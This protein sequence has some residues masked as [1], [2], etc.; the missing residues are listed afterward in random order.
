[1]KKIELGTRLSWLRAYCVIVVLMSLCFLAGTW[2]I[3]AGLEQNTRRFTQSQAQISQSILEAELESSYRYGMQLFYDYNVKNMEKT[4]LNIFENRESAYLTSVS[5]W[6]HIT[7]NPIIEDFYLYYPQSDY[8][9]GSKGVYPT[10][11]YGIL[12]NVSD[13]DWDAEQ[14]KAEIFAREAGF[15]L[16]TEDQQIELYYR[17][18]TTND[19][20]RILVAKLNASEIQKVLEYIG[21]SQTNNLIAIVDDQNTIYSWSGDYNRFADPAT[22]QLRAIDESEF[23]FADLTS[24]QTPL[25]Y[26][27]ITE[28]NAACRAA[29]TVSWI[30]VLCI[31]F[32]S[33]G[34]LLLSNYFTNKNMLPLL[35]LIGRY[36]KKQTQHET[37]NEMQEL[38]LI[39]DELSHESQEA[40]LSIEQQ[41]RLLVV[42]AFLNE[43]FKFQITNRQT[44]ANLSAI[45]DLSFE[46]TNYIVIVQERTEDY[47]S[48]D[49][50]NLLENWDD[51][52]VAVFWAQ[53]DNLDTFLI[54]FD[55]TADNGSPYNAFLQQLQECTKHPRNLAISSRTDN[56]EEIRSCWLD[57]LRQ[58]K[59]DPLSSDLNRT[60]A[61]NFQGQVLYNSFVQYLH[62]E[63]YSGAIN[64]APQLFSVYLNCGSNLERECKR[65]QIIRQLLAVQDAER[66]EQSIQNLADEP[67]DLHWKDSLCKVLSQ[68]NSVHLMSRQALYDGGTAA[69]IRAFIEEEYRNPSMD[70]RMVSEY[71]GLSESYVSK[72]FKKEYQIGISQYLNLVRIG[73]AKKWLR[74]DTL[75]I[76]AIALEVGYASDAHFIRIFKKLEGIT[77]GA[78][79]YEK[80]QET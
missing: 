10:E 33:A 21:S 45:Y 20:G 35:R 22:K 68:M 72:I 51:A 31:L 49:I 60:E 66:F 65:Y 15:F 70:L 73:H 11:V 79:R 64:L 78:Y 40:L 55:V 76:K 30:S 14:W 28:I 12:L 24:E 47:H 18:A 62:E 36:G 26:I 23:F 37:Q 57:C 16:T 74:T 8:V 61:T 50:I 7:A 63:A 80:R 6:N 43:C 34:A 48:K 69:K 58:L 13:P 9:I 44:I 59:R 56:L 29:E 38:E 75:S 17:L 71:V 19:T 54:N 1:M 53:R 42:N 4:D 41:K 25:H 52:A 2:V 46:N 32:S 77:P 39:I 27:S 3:F 67:I 5:M